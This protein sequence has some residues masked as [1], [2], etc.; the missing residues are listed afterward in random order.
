MRLLNLM[1]FFV[2]SISIS[3]AF[4]EPQFLILTDMH[5]GADNSAEEGKDTG[6]HFL[7]SALTK[8]KKLSKQVDFILNLG[9]L[10]THM[11]FFTANKGDYERTLFHGL[12]EADSALKPMFYIPGNNDSLG[13]NY[14]P[15]SVN[16]ISP[17][18]YAKDWDGACVY[19]N[20]LI[21]DK[22]HMN[23]GGY[24]S[25]YVIP[26]NKDIFLIALNST[27]F[28]EIPVVAFKYPNQEHDAE[29]ELTWLNQ[30][31]ADHSTKQVLIAMHIPPGATYKGGTMWQ[32]KYL[33]RFMAILERHA[34]A[35]GQITL[36]SGH[37][38]MDE[39]RKMRLSNGRIIYDYSTPAVSRIHNNNPGMKILSLDEEMAVK[40]YT[41]YYTTHLDSW[42]NEHY[43]ALGSAD[44]IFPQCHTK[45][46]AQCLDSLSDEEVCKDLE[47][48]LFYGVKSNRVP[49][50]GCHNTY[51]IQSKH[52]SKQF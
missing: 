48:G 46:L 7:N 18:T 22:T 8:M 38:H 6:P 37:T 42:G 24:Y 39:L 15:F 34:A 33:Q 52:R 27:P 12:Y 2:L 4:S 5:Y 14:Q 1:V 11:N 19:C 35:Y 20:D 16:G 44:A 45:T 47:K 40:N 13:G 21:I 50:G 3:T 17:L 28:A 26:K 32:E 31:L 10:P 36:L 30:Q 23:D 43:Q 51:L 9:D 29:T 25:T 41:T 49:N